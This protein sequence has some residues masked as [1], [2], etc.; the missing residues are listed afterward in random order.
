VKAAQANYRKSVEKGLLKIMSKMGIST[1]SSYRGAQIFEA[2]GLDEALVEQHFTGT[3]C[4]IGGVGPREI[5]TD[6]LRFHAEAY[7]AEPALRERGIYRFRKGGEY[8]AFN[9]AVFTSLHKAV[10]TGD[11]DGAY[12]S[13][14]KLVEERPP[15]ALRDLLQFRQ[16]EAAPLEEV[17]PA[18]EIARRFCTPG[19]SHGALSREAHE[20]LA[21]AM[22][23]LG[24]RSN[25]GEGGE[26]RERFYPY[27]NGDWGNSLIKQVASGRFGVTPEYLAVAGELEIKMAQGS[28][29]GE[30]G[31]IPGFKVSEE[32]AR[33]RHSVPGVTLISPPPHHDIYSIEDLAQLIYDLK[34][35]NPRAK[36]A[37]K[38]VSEAGIGTVAAGVAKGYADVIHI[39][40]HDGGT[41]ASPLGSIKNAGIPWE[42]G[43]A[44]T[45]QTLVMNDLR[46]RVRLRAD[47]G[48]K[49]GRDVV[50]AAL[51]GAEE[52]AF[53][54]AALV[55]AGCV[56]ARQCHMNNCPVGVAT[57][58]EDLRAKFPGSPEHVVQ[59]MLFVA[60][61]VREIL[62][63]MGVR[64]LDEIIGRTE[65]LEPRPIASFPKTDRI[66]LARV[67]ADPDPSGAKPR[68]SVQERNDRPGETL[69][70]RVVADVG[71]AV[72]TG[73]PVTREYEIRSTDRTV[74]GRLGGQIAHLHRDTGLPE[75]TIELHFRGSAGQSF[76]A[77]CNQGMRL[78]LAGEA[79]D[80]VG[81]SMAGGEIV[82][83]PPA[84]VRFRSHENTILGNT[85]MY[86][87][88][89][90]GL[91]A[92]GRAGERFCVRNSGGHAVVEGVGDHGCE[93]MTGGVVVILGETGRNF[94]AGMSGGI[95]FVL[96]ETGDFARRCNPE[97]VGTEPLDAD[98]D[99]DLV[100]S[101]IKKHLEYT[102]S[103]RARE[104]LARWEEYAPRFV[105][106]VP[107]P[108]EPGAK[109]QDVHE[110]EAAT[111]AAL[112]GEGHARL[113]T[114]R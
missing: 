29:P 19:M 21:I 61:Q 17:E 49:T 81:K 46:G 86:G 66:S 92:A 15:I 99:R 74:G 3:L 109:P 26:D 12:R 20:T 68:R 64:S 60:E 102:H 36:V 79:Q 70:D 113:I 55:S 7:G 94:G 13:Y 44:E 83:T 39:S 31:Q 24:A 23:R 97:M 33:I 76:G 47:G 88:T 85:V 38:L 101:F 41:G 18:P 16:G 73:E 32:I 100:G 4:P 111:L 107:H 48:F 22:N 71:E 14:V 42:L 91:Y 104:I 62:A 6:M 95:A 5:A 51:L 58:R 80:Y 1:L 103:A 50:M 105:K 8:H 112:Q 59:F 28:K 63:G 67:L 11:Y 54:T 96:D 114:V 72:R 87:A 57:Q 65:L 82:I 56:M 78:F 77:F 89:G 25:S 75:G 45:Q 34:R 10:R 93:Y 9:P 98:F 106:V 35:V 90:G 2:I 110:V 84:G 43:L 40:G 52:Y 69:D 53:G 108:A 37:V 27:E 30:G